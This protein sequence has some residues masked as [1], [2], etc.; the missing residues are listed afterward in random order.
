MNAAARMWSGGA[1]AVAGVL[2]WALTLAIFEPAIEAGA[3]G[4]AY[5]DAEAIEQM[6]V[7]PIDLRWGAMVLTLGGLLIAF[8]ARVAIVVTMP[9]WLALDLTMDGAQVAGWL[10]FGMLVAGAGVVLAA[11]VGLAIGVKSGAVQRFTSPDGAGHGILVYCGVAAA[12]MPLMFNVEPVTR[13]MRPPAMMVVAILLSLGLAIA[14]LLAA[15]TATTPSG[16][17]GIIVA[18]GLALMVA[19]PAIAVQW[20]FAELSNPGNWLLAVPWAAVPVLL[21]GCMLVAKGRPATT[22]GWVGTALQ[23]VVASGLSFALILFGVV[24]SMLVRAEYF[25][26]PGDAFQLIVGGLVAGPIIGVVAML[27]SGRRPVR[28]G[29][30]AAF[31]GEG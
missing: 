18:L 14:A 7:W 21:L 13:P 16:S 30:D 6:L 10:A 11:G 26:R 19:A 22:L 4:A 25:G 17:R 9:V 23:A 28:S 15:L 2:I 5:F 12:L 29:R 20:W 31:M 3:D 1:L 8:S 27:G 24:L